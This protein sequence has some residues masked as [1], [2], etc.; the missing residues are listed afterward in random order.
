MVQNYLEPRALN[1]KSC[2]VVD[3]QRGEARPHRGT[4][5]FGA[6]LTFKFGTY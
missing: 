2:P 6:K 4:D 5:K 3:H 1:G